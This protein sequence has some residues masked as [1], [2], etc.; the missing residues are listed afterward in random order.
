MGIKLIRN[1]SGNF[2]PTWF[3][4]FTRN[5][6]KVDRALTVKLRGKVPTTDDGQWDRT[7]KGD[8]VFE[9]SRRAAEKAFRALVRGEGNQRREIKKAE[10][11]LLALAGKKTDATPLSRLGQMWKSIERNKKPTAL[12]VKIA[13]KTFASFALFADTF[14]REH[15]F[16]CSTL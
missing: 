9:E 12:R 8:A 13:E 4:R 3:A 10:T 2:C 6:Q 11:T 16:R 1:G 5:G 15:G 14:A 7:A